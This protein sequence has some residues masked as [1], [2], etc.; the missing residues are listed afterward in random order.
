LI[1]DFVKIGAFVYE[2][3]VLQSDEKLGTS[4]GFNIYVPDYSGGVPQ[5]T[6][7]GAKCSGWYFGSEFP[8]WSVVLTAKYAISFTDCDQP[9]SIDLDYVPDLDW[10]VDILVSTIGV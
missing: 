4:L 9:I 8:K 1:Q 3:D 6:I 5:A 10:Q 2:H 7:S